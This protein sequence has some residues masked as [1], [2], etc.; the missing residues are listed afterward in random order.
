MAPETDF[1]ASTLGDKTAGAIGCNR[2][3]LFSGETRLKTLRNP[4]REGGENSVAVARR[5]FGA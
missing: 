2:V 1:G 5:D 3:Q 4:S